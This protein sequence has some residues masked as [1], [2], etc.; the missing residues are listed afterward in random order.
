M[1]IFS[2][3]GYVDF[4]LGDGNTNSLKREL[5]S[6]SIGPE[7]QQDMQSL[8]D[9]ENSSQENEI[10]DTKNRSGPSRQE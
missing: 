7:G 3:Y 5:N 8:S 6:I 4:M 1:V 10:R 2:K 9:R